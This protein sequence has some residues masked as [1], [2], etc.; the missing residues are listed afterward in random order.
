MSV[1]GHR[2]EGDCGNSDR[3][4][5]HGKVGRA[6]RDTTLDLPRLSRPS[7]THPPH[8]R[9]Q[10]PSPAAPRQVRGGVA[11][12]VTEDTEDGYTARRTLAPMLRS[13]AVPK[14]PS[15]PSSVI[16]VT[17]VASPA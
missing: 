10:Y 6:A 5:A 15:P 17:S 4:E 16:S 8:A 1:P 2:E 3:D 14:S 13:V 12:E 11:T 9:A 7:S